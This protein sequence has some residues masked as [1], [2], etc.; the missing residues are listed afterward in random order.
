MPVHAT[1]SWSSRPLLLPVEPV[2]QENT[3]NYFPINAHLEI[4]SGSRHPLFKPIRSDAVVVPPPVFHPSVIRTGKPVR[5]VRSFA[6][7]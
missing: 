1:T 4:L 2:L 5:F 6:W 7:W 3:F